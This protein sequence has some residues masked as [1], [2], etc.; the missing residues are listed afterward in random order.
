M[1]SSD[2]AQTCGQIFQSSGSQGWKVRVVVVVLVD[3]AV[4][5]VCVAVVVFVSVEVIVVVVIVMVEKD[6]TNG[7]PMKHWSGQKSTEKGPAAPSRQ[8]P[9]N[10]PEPLGG[11]Q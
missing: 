4:E 11:G 9:D 6:F 1:G 10:W 2:V 5:V 3:V 7:S 8:P